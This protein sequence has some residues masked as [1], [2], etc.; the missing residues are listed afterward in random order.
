MVKTNNQVEYMANIL[1]IDDDPAICRLLERFFQREN[2]HTDYALSLGDGLTKARQHPFDVI[3]LDVNLPDGNGLNA[4]AQITAAPSAPEVII[5]TGMGD[6]D[7]AELAI[8]TGAWTYIVK[9]PSM[10]DIMLQLNRALQYRREKA[11]SNSPVVL[12]REGIIGNSPQLAECLNQVAQVAVSDLSVLVTGET[13]TGKEMIA[14]AIHA[15]SARSEK[16]FIVVDCAS[17]PENLVGSMLFGHERGSFTG[18]QKDRIGLIRKADQGTLF[19]DEIG[20]L[21]LSL[22]KDFLRVLEEHRFRP[23][24]SDRERESDFRLIAATNRNLQKMVDAGQ[25][26]SDLLFRIKT[27]HVKLPPLRERAADIRELALHCM[28]GFCE[29]QGI[30]TKGF[31]PDFFEVL[32]NYNWPGNIRE[33]VNTMEQVLTVARF[34]PTIYPRHLPAAIRALHARTAVHKNMDKSD[35]PPVPNGQD[36]PALQSVRDAAVAQ[37]EKEY[38]Q[39]LIAHTRGDIKKAIRISGLSQSRFYHLLKKYG[40]NRR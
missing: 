12:K 35:T 16:Q 23:L 4:L 40:V 15:N 18:A 36:F 39:N 1:I 13:G 11:H 37:A 31:S 9:P 32:A 26:R 28:S 2:H 10:N 29:R 14:R 8:H 24:G 22:Q 34:E 6:P 7:G 33:L 19:L 20:E 21:P 17:L 25:F 3:F 5:L 27:F 30:E 38:L